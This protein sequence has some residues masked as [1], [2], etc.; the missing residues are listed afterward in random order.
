METTGDEANPIIWM[1]LCVISV[2]LSFFLQWNTGIIPLDGSHDSLRYLEM[3]QSLTDGKWLGDY[4]QMTLIRSPV[5][6]GYMAFNGIMGLALQHAQTF[7]YLLSVVLLSFSLRTIG[8]ESHRVAIVCIVCAFHPGAWIPCRFVATEGLYTSAVTLVLASAIGVMGT[9]RKSDFS[10]VFWIMVLSVSLSAA[11]RTR[12]ESLWL[13]PASVVFV[14]LMIRELVVMQRGG[15]NSRQMIVPVAAMV[16]PCLSVY[17]LTVWIQ[18]RNFRHYGVAVVNE[19]VEPG[20]VSAFSWLTRIDGET[21]HPYIPI[22]RQAMSD[23]SRI[24]LHFERL[25]PYLAQQLDGKGWSQFGCQM[26]GICDELAGGWAVWAVRDAASAVGVHAGAVHAA[27]FY[28]DLAGEIEAGCRTGSIAC[29]ANPT[30]NMLAP[31]MKGI[32]IPRIILSVPKVIWMTLWVADLPEAYRLIADKEPSAELFARYRPLVGKITDR[33][34]TMIVK[35]QYMLSWGYRAIHVIG[36]L[37]MLIIAVLNGLQRTQRGIVK[38]MKRYRCNYYGIIALI[39]VFISSRIAIISYIDAM[40]Y[41]AQ[42][43]YMIVIY[44]SLITLICF[45]SPVRCS[46]Y[47]GSPNALVSDIV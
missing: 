45:V 25:Y 39:V 19:L 15:V 32:D 18:H 33:Q 44:P 10:S 38:K 35:F 36:V 20:F 29:S 31:P 26:M 4:D 28:A 8:V 17:C 34:S 40:S 2:C 14:A 46:K 7:A 21:H 3:A 11:W 12:D 16:L 9:M 6:P 37:Y 42:S 22:T 30:G 23:A 27:A 13:V 5:Y 43:R 1:G 24:S 41:L 47:D